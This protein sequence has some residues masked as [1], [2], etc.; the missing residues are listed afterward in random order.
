MP[1]SRLPMS[2]TLLAFAALP[3]ISP[4]QEGEPKKQPPGIKV[5]AAGDP[6][7]A[8]AV[9]RLGSTRFRHQAPV[10]FV[11]YSGDGA[12]LITLSGDNI[13]RF[14]DAKGGKELRRLEL[15]A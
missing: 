6:L 3:I 7:P 8:G 12:I 4:A 13:L 10:S 2:L 11:G 15:K 1:T 9:A 5:D 14:W